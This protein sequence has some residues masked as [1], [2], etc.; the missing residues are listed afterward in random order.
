MGKAVR[1]ALYCGIALRPAVALMRSQI[2]LSG[3]E[4][5]CDGI[6]DKKVPVGAMHSRRDFAK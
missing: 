5:D 4:R 1:V 2:V 3:S 6:I